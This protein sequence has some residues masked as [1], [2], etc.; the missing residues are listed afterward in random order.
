MIPTE[1]RKIKHIPLNRNGK[2]DR[3]QLTQLYYDEGVNI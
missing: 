1:V 3:L 2:I